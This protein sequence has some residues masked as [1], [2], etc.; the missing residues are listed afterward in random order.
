MR[1]RS[2][3]RRVKGDTAATKLGTRHPS[4]KRH[5]SPSSTS[6]KPV[7]RH[8]VSETRSEHGSDRL[9]SRPDVKPSRNR[10]SR[11][12]QR[13]AK[14]PDR[15]SSI[16]TGALVELFAESQAVLLS[17]IETTAAP[18][19]LLSPDLI[20]LELNSEAERAYGRQRH[21][22]VSREYPGRLDHASRG[23]LTAE[24]CREVLNGRPVRGIEE[25]VRRPDGSERVLLWNAT[26]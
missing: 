24:L 12:A 25:R 3:R 5:V 2:S 22:L 21:G 23:G 8:S 16:A 4:A 9:K 17:L 7:A 26:A 18:I 20:L 10:S 6:S 15:R 11:S 14:V 13:A 1:K 19:L